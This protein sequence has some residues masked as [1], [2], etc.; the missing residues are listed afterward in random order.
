MAA[1]DP[2]PSDSQQLHG[3]FGVGHNPGGIS[4]QAIAKIEAKQVF[5]G[6]QNAESSSSR[7]ENVSHSEKIGIIRAGNL[8]KSTANF[9]G[10][11]KELAMLK[12][13]L[14]DSDVR[15]MGIGAIAGMGKST[16]AAKLYESDD[17]PLPKVY[18]VNAIAAPSFTTIAQDIFKEFGWKKDLPEQEQD[19]C[20]ALIKKLRAEACLLVIDNLE[21]LL[22]ETREWT[23]TFWQDFFLKWDEYGC[24][25]EILVTS[26][27]QPKIPSFDQ[28]LP[29]KGLEEDAGVALLKAKNI[30]G[31]LAKFVNR[32]GGH[33]LFLKI[34]ATFLDG[35]STSGEQPSLDDLPN[36]LQKLLTDEN[37]TV[38]HRGVEADLNTVLGFSFKR[39]SKIQQQIF[40][41]ASVFRS[42]FNAEMA[43]AAS[44]I[45]LEA[46]VIEK[47]LKHIADKSL[48]EITRQE[49]TRKRW[50][51]FHPVV[52]EY[53]QHEAVI[54]EEAH[55]NII[56][57]YQSTS[58][59]DQQSWQTLED[60]QEYLEIAHHWLVLG[61]ID[62]A[63][64]VIRQCDKFLTL[65]GYPTIRIEVYQPIITAYEKRDKPQEHWQYGAALID[66]GNAYRSLGEYDR[67]IAF[68]QQS[69]AI[70]REIGNRQV[71]AASFS[72]L[73]NAYKSLGEY[74][75]AIAFH[76]QH[77]EISREIGDR[78]GEAVSLGNL[79]NAYWSLGEY[80]RAI[81]FHQQYLD[82][83][84]EIG[85]R[86]GE[87]NSLGNLGNAYWSL[88]EY[89]RAIT[90]HQQYLD[91]AKEI[92]DRQGEANS[93]GN[94]GNAYQ[95]LGEYERAIAFHQQNL[96]IAK[97]IGDRQGEANSLGNL[98]NAYQSL[99]EYERAIAFLQ[100]NLDIAKEI[101]D[102]QGEANSLGNLGNA[103]Q[104]LGE[105]ERAIAFLQKSLEIKREIGDRQGEAKT[106]GNLGLAHNSLREYERA[107][108]FLQQS[109]EIQ[110]EIGDRRGEA[111]SL[112]NLASAY[113]QVGRVKD[114]IIAGQQAQQIMMDM[115]LP[116]DAYPIPKWMKSIARFAQK[117]KLKLVLLFIGGVF[118]FPFML[119]WFVLLISYRWVHRPFLRR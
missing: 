102:R 5:I 21:S 75:L 79:G 107:I 101:G 114:G 46:E 84:K 109:L 34:V 44:G 73:G 30:Q 86:Q 99:G 15:L 26:R 98:G 58:N 6:S 87:A 33:P 94:L 55:K 48:L 10:R 25:S 61:E 16:L 4:G 117:G 95:S 23:S 88:G 1:P 36:E 83:A 31:D 116:L 80:E 115:E 66:V 50:Y 22:T 69:L 3:N 91:I 78:Q 42:Q 89:E 71:E 111:N 118:A 93:L 11:E 70:F 57:F 85:D 20:E 12:G 56:D 63:F 43:R 59:K 108:A 7:P 68:Y 24:N 27:E 53:A 105:Y 28:W 37:A 90:F 2:N 113:Q 119:I 41:A 97:E 14:K 51:D 62:Q 92:G 47:E 38:T 72:G 29:L 74:E 112:M 67:A 77:L 96:D 49:K 35:E 100:Q 76:Q 81:A 104:S 110:R 8:A 32:F 17:L 52:K 19:Y 9:Q 45:E 65:R 64:S 103:Y 40:L 82:I 39:L 18:W 106:L 60:V 13:W 54:N